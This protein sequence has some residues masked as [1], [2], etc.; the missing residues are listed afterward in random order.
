MY[1]VKLA[2]TSGLFPLKLVCDSK[3]PLRLHDYSGNNICNTIA[4]D[5]AHKEASN[6]IKQRQSDHIS[7]GS[8]E[9]SMQRRNLRI[10][11]KDKMRTTI[12]TFIL[13][14]YS[15]F[16]RQQRVEQ[17]H[18]AAKG[19]LSSSR[20]W[21]EISRLRIKTSDTRAKVFVASSAPPESSTE[22]SQ[23]FTAT[24]PLPV[25]A[26]DGSLASVP[27]DPG[28]YAFYDKDGELQYIGLSRK[29]ELQPTPVL[30]CRNHR[31]PYLSP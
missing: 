7:E 6:V 27:S 19:S 20:S 23:S 31:W 30:A 5:I 1:P 2:W 22:I 21:T 10:T 25:R 24:E 28:I 17:S 18:K 4:E 8:A 11:R 15:L 13:P 12:S 14:T 16:C 9:S 3:W 26:E 29:V